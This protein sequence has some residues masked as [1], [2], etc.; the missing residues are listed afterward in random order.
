MA[1]PPE[2]EQNIAASNTLNQVEVESEKVT[3]KKCNDFLAKAYM[4]VKKQVTYQSEGGRFFPRLKQ[5]TQ[6]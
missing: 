2:Q 1:P 4:D 6:I 5:N 3:P